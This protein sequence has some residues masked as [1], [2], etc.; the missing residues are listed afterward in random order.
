MSKS[1]VITK[2]SVSNVMNE[3]KLLAS[4]AHPFIVNMEYAFQS[5][6]NLFLVMDLMPG[7]DL[8]YHLGRAGRFTEP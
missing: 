7:G 4:L 3:R 1:R 6:D 8:R 2:K 5:R